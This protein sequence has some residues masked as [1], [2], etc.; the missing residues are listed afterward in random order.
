MKYLIDLDG[1]LLDHAKANLDAVPFIKKFQEDNIKFMIMTNS[2]KS[3]TIVVERLESVGI[4]VPKANILNPITAINIY[5]EKEEISRAYIVGSSLEIEQ[6]SVQHETENPEMI[7]LLDFE[8]CNIDY[9]EL[10]KLYLLI[11]N[12]VPAIA[13]SGSLYYLK[14]GIKQLD[15][16]S[17]VKLL[18]Q[19]S[20]KDII[21]LG[22]PSIEYFSAGF[23]SLG[24][25][26]SG[27][28]IIG[29]D[30]AT[31][32]IGAQNAGCKSVLLRSGKY[33]FGD[34]NKCH[35]DRIANKLMDCM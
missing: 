8:K 14:D 7:I 6:V 28:T 34:E 9:S 12:N 3:P 16:G 22:K 32:I 1:T 13:A 2:I 35:P 20:N 19:A 4:K 33:K 21:I 24:A 29:D 23:S 18:E 11:Q 26:P 31:D 5:L 15:T 10:Q 17:F 25:H 30:Y 27:V